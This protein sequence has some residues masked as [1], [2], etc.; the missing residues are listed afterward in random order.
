MSLGAHFAGENTELNP[1]HLVI[2]SFL[3]YGGGNCSR[4]ILELGPCRLEY[5]NLS[6]MVLSPMKVF[7]QHLSATF[8]TR[9]ASPFPG[10]SHKKSILSYAPTHK[11][12]AEQGAH[13]TL[14]AQLTNLT[15][16]APHQ[17]SHF[18]SFAP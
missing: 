15:G 1:G 7:V 14:I 10:K 18:P 6:S 13:D 16:I 12:D 8:Y 17:V 3:G 4:G 2:D 11:M 9:H 5:L